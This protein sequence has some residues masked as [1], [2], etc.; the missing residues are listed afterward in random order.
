M[1]PPPG[2]VVLTPEEQAA[3]LR[4]TERVRHAALRHMSTQA[5]AASTLAFVRHI[6]QSVD[7]VVGAAAERGA[8]IDCQA[9]CSHCCNARVEA[10]APEVFQI[11][12]HL[13]ALA[14]V[15]LADTLDRL[16][17]HAAAADAPAAG[18]A[19]RTPCPFLVQRLCSIYPVR[20]AACR[21]AHSSDAGR[22]EANAPAIPQH[23]E[24]V[25]KAEA[26][27]SGT[28]GAY[29]ERGLDGARHELVGA[30]LRALREPS[31]QARWQRGEQVFE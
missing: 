27:I 2:D 17:A 30:V 31:A 10:L 16:Q 14:P 18:W 9:G 29:R 24:V 20:P 6:Q 22:C 12:Q 8:R 26:L 13:E 15:A 7:R 25:L 11:A 3:F 19:E 1:N 4:S 5:G 28:A 21:K 23:L